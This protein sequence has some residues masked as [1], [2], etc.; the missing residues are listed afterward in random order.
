VT[1]GTGLLHVTVTARWVPLVPRWLW[2]AGGTA[3]EH[4]DALP[5]GDGALGQNMRPVPD[6]HWIV[7]KSLKGSRQAGHESFN[8]SRLFAA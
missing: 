6:D 5:D 2:H 1:V 4:D 8:L 3:G 7:S